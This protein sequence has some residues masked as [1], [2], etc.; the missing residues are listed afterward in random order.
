MD[1]T[2][3]DNALKDLELNANA[4]SKLDVKLI[5]SFRRLMNSIQN[6]TDENDLRALPGKHFEKM[7][8]DYEGLYTMRLNKQWRLFFSII[9]GTP[10]NTIHIIKIDDPH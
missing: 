10:K 1:V 7:S 9:S 3:E 2:Y 4:K 5:K 8:G 6:A